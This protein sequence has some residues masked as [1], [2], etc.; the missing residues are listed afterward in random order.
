MMFLKVVIYYLLLVATID[1]EERLFGFLRWL[2]VF[3]SLLAALALLSW[4]HV[5]E[6]PSIT[7]LDERMGY[8]EFGES[9][10]ISRLRSTG[11]FNDP[12]DLAMILTVGV[13]LGLRGAFT[14]DSS[15][16][17][18]TL[19]L[20]LAGGLIYS[21]YLTQSR[22]GFLALLAALGA[23]AYFRWG[24][25]R[26]LLCAALALPLMLVAMKGRMTSFDEAMEGGTGHSRIEL[27]SEGLQLFRQSPLF[28]IGQGVF[29]D[30]VGLVAHNSYLHTFAELGLFG[31]ALFLGSFLA[32]SLGLWGC[33][34]AHAP[35]TSLTILR[36]AGTMMGVLAGTA[37]ALFSITRVYTA[38]TYL[39][40][41]VT[42]S[43]TRLAAID[44]G[45][46]PLCFDR[47]FL[48]RLAA[49]SVLFLAL[50]Y[51]FVRV[52]LRGS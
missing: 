2:L 28:G 6:I 33:R 38:P 21:I 46:A 9:I 11:I 3:I 31:G 40:L 18:R 1:S 39:L 24:A 27:W 49:V 22:G 8:D 43:F 19:S 41:G 14:S 15:T 16:L 37:V 10:S 44:S 25:K 36:E 35:D 7:A 29:A 30:E 51:V 5:V 23:L 52:G 42:A 48:K 32:G 20:C 12:N 17:F 47:V 34:N 4:F 45:L 50:M 13:V 26:T